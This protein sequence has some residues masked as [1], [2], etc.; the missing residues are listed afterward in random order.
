MSDRALPILTP[1]FF[2]GCSEHASY[3]DPIIPGYRGNPLIEALPPIWSSDEVARCLMRY[4]EYDET[5]RAWPSELRFHLIRNAVNFFEPLPIHLDELSF[6]STNDVSHACTEHAVYAH[7]YFISWFHYVDK[8][9]F[10]AGAAC[11]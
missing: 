2:R 10:H 5:Q 7:N 11:S 9:G 1:P 4:P 6:Q 3:G 8:T